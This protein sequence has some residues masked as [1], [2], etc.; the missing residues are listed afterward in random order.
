MSATL[1]NIKPALGQRV[2]FIRYVSKCLTC[3]AVDARVSGDTVTHIA[4]H[5]IYTCTSINTGGTDT[6]VDI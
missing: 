4:V 5:L 6:F 3:L 2:V 1:P